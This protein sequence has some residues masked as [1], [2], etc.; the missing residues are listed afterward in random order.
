V[1]RRG[2]REGRPHGLRAA[3]RRR[4]AFDAQ[5]RNAFGLYGKG[6]CKT[7]RRTATP[8][9]PPT[10][11]SPTSPV[12]RTLSRI[13]PNQAQGGTAKVTKMPLPVNDSVTKDVHEV[14]LPRFASSGRP[15][16]AEVKQSPHIANCPVASIL[17]AHAFTELRKT[18]DR[19]RN[20]TLPGDEPASVPSNRTGRTDVGQGFS[21]ADWCAL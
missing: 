20:R 6:M 21:P 19:R 4:S 5:R 2:L 13:P 9:L 14:A 15:A 17:A 12:A 11:G 16:F 3:L 10:A 7:T 8:P 1:H 18:L